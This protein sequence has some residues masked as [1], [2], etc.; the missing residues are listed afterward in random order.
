MIIPWPSYISNRLPKLNICASL[1]LAHDPSHSRGKWIIE[2]SVGRNNFGSITP[3]DALTDLE[4]FLSA[5]R[6]YSP[7]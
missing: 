5:N 3:L 4:F 2:E 7:F 6:D 1:R